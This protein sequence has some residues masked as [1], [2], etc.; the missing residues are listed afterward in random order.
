MHRRLAEGIG[1]CS[2]RWG[3][4]V[5]AAVWLAACATPVPR[6]SAPEP[7]ERDAGDSAAVPVV[8]ESGRTPPAALALADQ[9]AA[10]RQAGD[11][12]LAEQR[13][14]RALRIAPRDATLWHRMAVL[15]LE[16][17]RYQQAERL[18]E[19]SLRLA[20]GRDRALVLANWRVRLAAREALGDT[21]GAARAREKIHELEAE[22]A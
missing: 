3:V 8:P 11:H 13:L 5:V 17:A 1:R 16:Q 14:E 12:G 7:V 15:R 4:V 6:D 19:R 2:A 9:A 10:A 22:S 20:G 21:A 18:A